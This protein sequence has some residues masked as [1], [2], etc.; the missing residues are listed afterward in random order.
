MKQIRTLFLLMSLPLT[1]I[2]QEANLSVSL[3][4][5]AP[6]LKFRSI[7]RG[8][9]NQVMFKSYWLGGAINH[10][11]KR[12]I[13]LA[14]QMGYHVDRFTYLTDPYLPPASY[15]TKETEYKFEYYE[16]SQGINYAIMLN[17]KF[18]LIAQTGLALEMPLKKEMKGTKYNGATTSWGPLSERDDT[19]GLVISPNIELSLK[20][21]VTKKIH[22]QLASMYSSYHY[23]KPDG[24]DASIRSAYSAELIIGYSF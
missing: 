13:G 23:G 16:L 1:V 17:K 7:E 11:F 4:Y 9:Y 22:I 8:S 14:F 12:N 6:Y 18:Y 15:D 24:I 20:Y 3:G 2:C 21:Q 19:N 10:T 5:Q